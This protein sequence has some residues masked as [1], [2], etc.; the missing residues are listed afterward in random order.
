M[1]HDEL[2]YKSIEFN[3][4]TYIGDPLV[5]VKI[6]N[7]KEAQEICIVDTD[8]NRYKKEINFNLLKD[9]ASECFMP[10]CYGGGVKTLDDI[11]TLNKIG[12]E[13]VILNTVIHDNPDFVKDAINE[14][15]SSTII[16][17]I[18]FKIE[19]NKYVIYKNGGKIKTNKNVEDLALWL[20]ERQI[21]EL[22]LN[23]IDRD[24]KLNG[25]DLKLLSRISKLVYV[26]IIAAGGIS[27]I[28]NIK[29]GFKTGINAIAAGS[30]FVYK[31][32]LKGILINYPDKSLLNQILGQ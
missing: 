22:L 7:E 19:N 8:I 21:G 18:D 30:I 6:F 25:L 11:R 12:F 1:L 26:P 23:N 28:Q 24:G 31:G 3:D 9:I 32:P 16:G 10:L 5:A 29:D 27:S 17:C 14:F 13:K 2:L 20:Q 15:G 4:Y